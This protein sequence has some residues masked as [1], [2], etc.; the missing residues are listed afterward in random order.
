MCLDTLLPSDLERQ[1]LL[2]SVRLSHKV[3]GLIA[4]EVSD[5]PSRGASLDLGLRHPSSTWNKIDLISN[6]FLNNNL[7]LQR[8]NITNQ[9]G[10]LVD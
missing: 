7:L 4:P 6:I 9:S 5:N 1:E 3:A 2:P 10:R 8:Y